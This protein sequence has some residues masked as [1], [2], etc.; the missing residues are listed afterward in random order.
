MFLPL[1]AAAVMY[2][3][4][5][6]SVIDGDT[7]KAEIP[8][9][10]VP[11]NPVNVRING[12]DTPEHVMPPAQSACEVPLGLAATA[13]TKTFVHPGD[14]VTFVYTR[15][16]HDKYDRLLATMTLANGQD[17]GSIMVAHGYARPY[18]QVTG[19]HKPPWC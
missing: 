11:W 2:H 19:L 1:L 6:I 16:T 8:G 5:I 10:P 12:I 7:V 18:N 17:Y 15:G 3:G 9:F 14:K 13:F 4:T